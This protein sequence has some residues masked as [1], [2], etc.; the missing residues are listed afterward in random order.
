MREHTNSDCLEET[1]LQSENSHC[2]TT[3]K[4]QQQQKTLHLKGLRHVA[5]LRKQLNLKRVSNTKQIPR[6]GKACYSK[7]C[8]R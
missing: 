3:K 1:F 2:E 7:L 6:S 5:A 4:N 8:R